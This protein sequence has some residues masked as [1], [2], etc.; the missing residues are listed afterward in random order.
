[1]AGSISWRAPRAEDRDAGH[2]EFQF[3]QRAERGPF[4]M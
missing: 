4:M 2:N 3:T 1:L